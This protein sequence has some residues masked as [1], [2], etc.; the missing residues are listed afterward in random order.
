MC[1]LVGLV[2][3]DRPVDAGMFERMRDTLVHRGPDDAGSAY[4]DTGRIALGHRRLSFLDLSAHGRQPL[5]NEDGS[6]WVVFN[7]EIYNFLELREELLHAGHAFS[8]ST[9]TEVLVHGYE[10]WGE[11]LVSRLK[12]MFAFAIL[13][14]PRR[15][16]FLARDR[17]GIKPLYWTLQGGR[18]ALPQS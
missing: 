14:L 17:F 1:G 13:D 9:D 12:G 11:G 4:F 10:A 7:G 3:A 5:S 2:Q 18:F 16:L 6:V 15:R 8:S